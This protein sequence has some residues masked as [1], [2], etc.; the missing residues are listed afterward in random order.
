M[1]RSELE[2]VPK[3]ARIGE[4][5]TRLV[6]PA[7]NADRRCPYIFKTA[8]HGRIYAAW[9]RIKPTAD[10][11]QEAWLRDPAPGS[12]APGRSQ[13]GALLTSGTWVRQAVGSRRMEAMFRA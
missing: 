5:R 10:D 13:P 9:F 1:L 11:V 3:G 8:H 6:I 2:K 7:W 4:A 12:D